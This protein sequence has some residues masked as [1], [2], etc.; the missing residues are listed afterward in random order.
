MVYEWKK[1]AAGPTG[2][3]KAK[4]AGK[5]IKRLEKKHGGA[6]PTAI[7]DEA[8][9][10][11]SPIHPW[12]EWDDSAAA[13]KYRQEQARS[14]VQQ[15]VVV[16]ESEGEGE[17]IEC[18]AFVTVKEGNCRHYASTARVLGD[19]ELRQQVINDVLSDISHC[20]SKLKA[21]DGFGKALVSLDK[22]QAA[23]QKSK[24]GKARHGT[25]RRGTARQVAAV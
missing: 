22:A 10:D 5:I 9:P 20:K 15:I 19:D 18:R 21:F 1:D 3:V 14:M 4:D 8:R 2:K 13:E 7:V 25:A 11:D 23:I 12:F 6:T 24:A 16:C 17:P